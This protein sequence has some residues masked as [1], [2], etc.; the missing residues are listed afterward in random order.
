MK[1][2]FQL[3]E[4]L[5]G[6]QA[7]E[8]YERFEE[9]GDRGIETGFFD[10]DDL[11]NG[12]HSSELSVVASRPSIGKTSLVLNLIEHASIDAKLPSVLFTLEMSRAGV[13]Q[14]LMASRTQ[15]DS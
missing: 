12:L 9:R 2:H 11:L 8:S 10:L 6:E 14:R 5:I 7:M 3:G 4:Y 13:A 1:T 15:L